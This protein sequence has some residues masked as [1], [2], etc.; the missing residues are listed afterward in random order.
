MDDTDD[1]DEAARA[2][3]LLAGMLASCPTSPRLEAEG[4]VP[5][6]D[7]SGVAAFGDTDA[8]SSPAVADPTLKHL[9]GLA[10]VSPSGARPELRQSQLRPRS[11]SPVHTKTLAVVQQAE[12]AAAAATSVG[13]PA[14]VPRLALSKVLNQ[15]TDHT[16][17]AAALEAFAIIGTLAEAEGSDSDDAEASSFATTSDEDASLAG[18]SDAEPAADVVSKAADAV[19]DAELGAAATPEM[20]L[21][22]RQSPPA[23]RAP[24]RLLWPLRWRPR[25]G[26]ALRH[27]FCHRRLALFL[28]A[29]A[30]QFM[31]I[32]LALDAG[33]V[34]S[35]ASSAFGAARR[36]FVAVAVALVLG[37][38]ALVYCAAGLWRSAN[39]GGE[40]DARDVIISAVE[41]EAQ[42]LAPTCT[43]PPV[44]VAPSAASAS[45][46]GSWRDSGEHASE[47]AC[48]EPF[49]AR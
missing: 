12:A 15:H 11:R 10:A 14:A 24:P 34:P 4:A 48:A 25:L 32:L 9:G 13:R 33:H 6:L 5:L 23:G 27:A 30:V 45:T 18:A 40:V 7:V 37:F 26:G 17:E 21:E 22:V 20:R 35:H 16:E 28:A 47:R 36:G 19:I 43:A 39:G 2:G 49:R 42:V 38:A 29:A 44:C 31:L 41:S 3:L 8:S 1:T 46:S